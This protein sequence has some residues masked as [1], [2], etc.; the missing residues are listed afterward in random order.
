[1]EYVELVHENWSNAIA[2]SDRPIS[3]GPK[4]ETNTA[5]TETGV[6]TV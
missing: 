4:Y 1:M 2:F 3:T 6:I 5:E